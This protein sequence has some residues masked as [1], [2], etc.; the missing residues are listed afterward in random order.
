[1]NGLIKSLCAAGA[2][3]MLSTT[4]VAESFSFTST[5]E[6]TGGVSIPMANGATAGAGSSAGTTNW[7]WASGKKSTST[8]VCYSMT[9]RAGELFALRGMCESTQ[10]GEVV[11]SVMFGCNYLN[12][13]RTETN[14]VGGLIGRAGAFE[15]KTGTISWHG[16]DGTSN[17]AGHWN[18]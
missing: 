12:E 16:K 15:G 11:S 1:M 7:T 5:G 13:E 17:G 2:A 6:G 8:Y 9:D 14:C 18:D 10:D 3:L 4:A